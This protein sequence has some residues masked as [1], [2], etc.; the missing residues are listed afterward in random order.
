MP[1]LPRR[2]L[3]VVGT[4]AMIWVGGGIIVHGLEEFG[5]DGPA[6]LDPRHAE[7]AAPRA[8]GRRRRCRMAGRRGGSGVVGLVSAPR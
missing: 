5:F 6:H 1:V 2:L 8:A 3:G 4:A 7:A